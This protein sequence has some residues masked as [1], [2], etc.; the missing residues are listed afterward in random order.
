MKKISEDAREAL[1]QAENVVAENIKHH[2]SLSH[3]TDAQKEEMSRLFSY[4]DNIFDIMHRLEDE[5]FNYLDPN[6]SILINIL[7]LAV[8]AIIA[9]Q[10]AYELNDVLKEFEQDYE[11]KDTN[12]LRAMSEKL[13]RTFGHAE[14]RA[15]EIK[16][17]A[18]P[19]VI[20]GKGLDILR[21]IE[22]A[23]KK[24]EHNNY[25]IGE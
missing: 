2:L 15:G 19:E 10:F 11:L 5:E 12:G 16:D 14:G 13:T 4:T 8:K 7:T 23:E 25:E 21:E 3:L 24:A 9:P 6:R 20:N 17:E 18:S 1:K 22:E